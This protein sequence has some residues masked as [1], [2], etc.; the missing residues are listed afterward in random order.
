MLSENTIVF[1]NKEG[2]EMV[3]RHSQVAKK[4]YVR[5]N[6]CDHTWGQ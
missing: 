1:N 6:S 4:S 5:F 3:H 2:N